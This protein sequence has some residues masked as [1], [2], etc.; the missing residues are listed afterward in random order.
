MA[1]PKKNPVVDVA[2]GAGISPAAVS[3]AF[4]RPKLLS[5]EAL[6]GVMRAAKDLK[7]IQNSLAR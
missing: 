4:N 1:N 5:P 3:Q 2:A 7:F 6:D